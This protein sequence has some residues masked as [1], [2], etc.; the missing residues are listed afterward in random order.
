VYRTPNGIPEQEWTIG[1][2]K[3]KC[4]RLV[5]QSVYRTPDGIPEQEWTI[6]NVPFRVNVTGQWYSLSTG[7]LME[8]Q[9]RNGPEVTN[10]IE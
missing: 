5:V 3:S 1:N 8:Y 9:S 6:G 2:E 4:Y 10:H 7:H